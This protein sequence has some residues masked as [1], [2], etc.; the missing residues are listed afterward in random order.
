MCI[1][2]WLPAHSTIYKTLQCTTELNYRLNWLCIIIQKLCYN[3][4][5]P[6]SSFSS[7]SSPSS[8]INKAL[9][10]AFMVGE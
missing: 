1:S 4:T 5:S 10:M 7:P 2:G 3:W 8:T 9:H 6:P